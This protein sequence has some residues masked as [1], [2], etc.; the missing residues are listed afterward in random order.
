MPKQEV[1]RAQAAI[2]FSR[3]LQK[4]SVLQDAPLN[5]GMGKG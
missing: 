5:M 1:S 4:R 2:A 3:Y